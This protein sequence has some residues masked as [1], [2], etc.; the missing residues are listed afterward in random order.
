MSAEN[1]SL[2]AEVEALIGEAK[3]PVSYLA[4]SPCLTLLG[5]RNGGR[6]V[7]VVGIEA[8]GSVGLL[9]SLAVEPAHRNSGIG[10]SLVSGAEAWAAEQGIEILY[11]LTTTAA[12]FFARRGHEAVPR[13]AAPAAIAETAQ[14]RDLC[15]AS[16]TLMCKVLAAQISPPPRP[17]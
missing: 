2:T 1:V 12:V 13:S 5:I 11:L 16:S 9:R 8:Y 15:P 10:T 3:L 14:F 6:L 17:A 7:G 4:S